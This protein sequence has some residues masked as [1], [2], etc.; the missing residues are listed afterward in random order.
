MRALRSLQRL[1]RYDAPP[2]LAVELRRRG[3]SRE[4]WRFAKSAGDDLLG[5][6]F[7][8]P[9]AS[10]CLELALRCG[11]DRGLVGAAAADLVAAASADEPASPG[12]GQGAPEAG[13]RPMSAELLAATEEATARL[14]GPD[15][16]IDDFCVQIEELS[17]AL[18]ESRHA[19]RTARAAME[20]AREW[21]RYEELLAATDEY[22]A[23]YGAAHLELASL[24]RRRVPGE[25]VRAALEG[26]RAHP[27]R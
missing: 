11:V 14:L 2:P 3:A 6:W 9:R 19:V 24:V 4:L 10:L 18:V 15:G 20:S 25:L 17:Y 16:A 27:Y 5:V 13:A 21:G 26:A 7:A 8:C 23:A 12:D 22:D 1:L